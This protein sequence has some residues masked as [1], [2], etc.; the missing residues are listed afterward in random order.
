MLRLEVAGQGAAQLELPRGPAKPGA[1]RFV[2]L[3]DAGTGGKSQ[4]RIADRMAIFHTERPFDTVILL[5]DN[6]YP[7]GRA[8]DLP[9]KFE[10]PYAE[11]L[12]RGVLFYAALGNHDVRQGREAQINYKLFNMGGRAYYSFSKEDN[13]VEFF[14]ADSTKF[15]DEQLRWLEGAL[16]RSTA[17]WKIAYLHHPLYSSGTRHGSSEALRFRVEPLFVRYKVAAVFSGH[18]HFYERTLPQQQVQYFVSGAGGKIRRGNINRR[19]RFFAAGNDDTNSFVYVE[20]VEDQLTFWA[21]DESGNV[22][23]SGTI[24]PRRALQSR[25]ASWTFD[26]ILGG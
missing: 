9:G 7:N 6:I 23:D 26:K 19:S 5:G 1:V 20:A 14:V 12:S 13:L 18:D 3:G 11:L 16:K 15:D 8:S 17:R 4:Q 21:I 10:R 24:A 2:A 22:L 25:T